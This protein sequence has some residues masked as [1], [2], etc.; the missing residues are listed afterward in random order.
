M[1]VVAAEQRRQEQMVLA[2][3]VVVG[4]E[5]LQER[6]VL[7]TQEA[8]EVAVHLLVLVQQAAQAS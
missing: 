3:Q 5:G 4:L 6:L 7:R 8:V 2:A 1:L